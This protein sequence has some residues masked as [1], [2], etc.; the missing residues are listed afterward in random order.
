MWLLIIIYKT[1]DLYYIINYKNKFSE[2]VL[3][4]E[5]NF[6]V[7]FYVIAMVIVINSVK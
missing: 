6:N 5:F 4:T 2:I 3:N 7:V 1:H